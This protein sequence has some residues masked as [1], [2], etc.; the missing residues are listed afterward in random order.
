MDIE[1]SKL[2]HITDDPDQLANCD[3]YIITVPTPIDEQ[4]KPDL[5]PILS[6]TTL[7]SDYINEGDTIIY[8]STVYPGLTEEICAPLIEKNTS[9]EYNKDFSAVIVQ[10][11]LILVTKII[12]LETLQ[13]L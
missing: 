7:I 8:E 13:K 6:A 9:L 3:V 11:G 5:N 10:K 12:R 4:S 2:L 1:S